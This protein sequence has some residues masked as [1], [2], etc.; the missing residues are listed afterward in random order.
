MT[1]ADMILREP[2]QVWWT[3]TASGTLC[4]QWCGK[5]LSGA[6]SVTYLNGNQ[7]VCDLCL[8]KARRNE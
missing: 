3:Q 4:C 1:I 6:S 2:P 5:D 8:I 7:A